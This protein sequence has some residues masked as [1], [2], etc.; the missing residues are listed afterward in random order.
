MHRNVNKV[1][2][3][4]EAIL[5][6]PITR[7]HIKQAQ[8]NYFVSFNCCRNIVPPLVTYVLKD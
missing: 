8:N 4:L 1:A 3:K 7:H 2:F 5:I 6:D